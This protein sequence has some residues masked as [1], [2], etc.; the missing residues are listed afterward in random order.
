[1]DAP[2]RQVIAQCP[3]PTS[4]YAAQLGDPYESNRI[5]HDGAVELRN[6][7][8]FWR[9]P[10]YVRSAKQEMDSKDECISAIENLLKVLVQIDNGVLNLG[11]QLRKLR[12]EYSDCYVDGQFSSQSGGARTQE[13]QDK[14]DQWAM[15]LSQRAKK[16]IVACNRIAIHLSGLVSEPTMWET[17]LRTT[18]RLFIDAITSLPMMMGTEVSESHVVGLASQLYA[19]G[20]HLQDARDTIAGSMTD[21]SSADRPP[22][23][24]P[25]GG[26]AVDEALRDLERAVEKHRLT[27]LYVA[28]PRRLEMRAGIRQ[29][30]TIDRSSWPEERIPAEAIDC[31]GQF[32]FKYRGVLER[33]AQTAIGRFGPGKGVRAKEWHDSGFVEVEGG[34]LPHWSLDSGACSIMESSSEML[35][36][37]CKRLVHADVSRRFNALIRLTRDLLHDGDQPRWYE[38]F[39]VSWDY[40]SRLEVLIARIKSAEIDQLDQPSAPDQEEHTTSDTGTESNG[41]EAGNTAIPQMSKDQNRA[42]GHGLLMLLAQAYYKMLEATISTASWCSEL[43]LQLNESYLWTIRNIRNLLDNHEDLT[44][45]PQKFEP[46][47][48]DLFPSTIR[49]TEWDDMIAPGVEG[50][51][52]AVQ[53]YLHASGFTEPSQGSHAWTFIEMFRDGVN[54]A[55]ERAHNYAARMRQ[56]IRRLMNQP[57]ADKTQPS[58]TTSTP[59]GPVTSGEL[60][61]P[62][63]IKPDGVHPAGLVIWNGVSH[64]CSLS[65]SEMT[66]MSLALMN[67]HI[68]IEQIM[69]KA[70]EVVWRERYL[71]TRKQREKVG[72]FISRLSTKLLNAT[73]PIAMSFSLSRDSHFIRRTPAMHQSTDISRTKE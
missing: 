70:G 60:A 10:Y 35:L 11:T 42:A 29:L 13:I 27:F 47:F 41:P 28:M 58:K 2:S 66:L 5:I 38:S 51:L 62:T 40:L 23:A 67:D 56:H 4:G 37:A 16:S 57:V 1:M 32:L 52:S 54:T 25:S 19:F 12:A 73:P 26:A 50:F 46:A 31:D 24:S 64:K 33:F 65:K 6:S 69:N 17:E 53:S 45:F 9:Y 20:T 68:Q 63:E 18:L 36:E 48:P 14:I 30:E 8:L 39:L 71:Q 34:S 49:D 55:I 7:G 61:T 72:K 3:R 21:S 22:S 43:D 44:D 15:P 59:P